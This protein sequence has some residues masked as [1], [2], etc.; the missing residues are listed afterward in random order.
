MERCHIAA[1]VEDPLESFQP[2]L[3][4]LNS[5][6]N[7]DFQIEGSHRTGAVHDLYP[8][9]QVDRVGETSDAPDWSRSE[10]QGAVRPGSAGL[11]RFR[12]SSREGL[13][14][15]REG[16][17][18]AVTIRSEGSDPVGSVIPPG[19]EHHNRTVAAHS[20]WDRQEEVNTGID[21]SQKGLQEVSGQA[22]RQ[23]GSAGCV[24][25]SLG[26]LLRP[27]SSHGVIGRLAAAAVLNHVTPEFLETGS[28]NREEGPQVGEKD[29]QQQEGPTSGVGP[30]F[31]VTGRTH[32]RLGFFGGS[33]TADSLHPLAAEIVGQIN[34]LPAVG[35]RSGVEAGPSS[36]ATGTVNCGGDGGSMLILEGGGEVTNPRHLEVSTGRKGVDSK[37]NY[38]V[39][40]RK[41]MSQFCSPIKAP[42][43]GTVLVGPGG[44]GQDKG[45]RVEEQ[46][47][48]T[49]GDK[50][51][52]AVLGIVEGIGCSYGEV[53]R[54]GRLEAV[55]VEK[56]G[57]DH[58]DG[59]SCMDAYSKKREMGTERE[60]GQIGNEA[61]SG[62]SRAEE[63]GETSGVVEEGT[64]E[65][66]LSFGNHWG[67]LRDRNVK[68]LED[69][70][71]SVIGEKGEGM[72][73]TTEGGEVGGLVYGRE[74]DERV[75][76]GGEEDFQ[77]EEEE[78][79]EE[80]DGDTMGKNMLFNGA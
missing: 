11:T 39:Y 6:L 63:D 27:H 31:G 54:V 73:F 8:V 25:P 1:V 32:C 38:R 77:T 36:Q 10:N 35:P 59:D 29:D 69:V 30:S 74:E 79:E 33:A 15:A 67:F 64:K 24:G 50:D 44:S 42:C 57:E 55:F 65:K 53:E 70:M 22:Q 46:D 76:L 7:F 5:N 56:G 48:V 72:V 47:A 43:E 52:S 12:E 21:T 40:K 75:N 13:N 71:Y 19:F 45:G 18:G 28:V 41:Q 34:A 20:S 17:Q 68:A 14:E 3:R 51:D 61:L 26:E 49:E 58:E 60:E 66:V 80:V 16:Y 78:E 62:E 23:G 9:Q 2:H 37:K 4:N